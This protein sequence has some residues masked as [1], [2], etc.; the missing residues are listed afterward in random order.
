MENAAWSSEKE[1]ELLS[2]RKQNKSLQESMVTL[3]EAKLEKENENRYIFELNQ[4]IWHGFQLEK[5][6]K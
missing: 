2:L 5:S 3:L 6:I 4:E 1:K